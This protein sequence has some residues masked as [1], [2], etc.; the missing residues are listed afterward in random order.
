MGCTQCKDRDPSQEDPELSPENHEPSQED[1]EL[2]L[3]ERKQNLREQM[4]VVRNEE[5]KRQMEQIEWKK[6]EA[7]AHQRALNLLYERTQARAKQDF[8]NLVTTY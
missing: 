7:E 8:E 1:P 5:Q 4:N 3:E 6:R 2:S